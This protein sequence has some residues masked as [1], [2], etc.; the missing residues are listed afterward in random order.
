M[1][2]RVH[3]SALVSLL[4]VAGA[5]CSEEAVMGDPIEG[6]PRLTSIQVNIFTPSC[7]NFSPCHDSSSPA[8]ALDLTEGVS[9]A[10]LV[11]REATMDPSRMLVIPGDP[12]ESFLIQ[13]LRG[14]LAES[15]GVRMPFGNPPLPADQVS[16]IEEWVARGAAND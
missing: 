6:E 12:D 7:A 8:G 9:H 3:R 15:Q 1:L 4:L 5:G 10:Q 16:I 11:G 13:K 2:Q 14:E